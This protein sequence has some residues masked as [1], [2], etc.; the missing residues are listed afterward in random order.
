[1]LLVNTVAQLELLAFS[2]FQACQR[3]RADIRQVV[4][5]LVIG[6]ALSLLTGT[7][8]DSAKP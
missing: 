8:Q 4:T 3:E 5:V 1:M 6:T 7:L 2:P